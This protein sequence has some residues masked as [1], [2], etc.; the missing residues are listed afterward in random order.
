M[1]SWAPCCCKCGIEGDRSHLELAPWTISGDRGPYP[2]CRAYFCAACLEEQELRRRR[3]DALLDPDAG[4]PVNPPLLELC[5]LSTEAWVLRHAPPNRA[6]RA[7]LASEWPVPAGRGALDE[8]ARDWNA[9]ARDGEA[10]LRPEAL[11]DIWEGLPPDTYLALA[12]QRRTPH[13]SVWLLGPVQ[14]VEE[15]LDEDGGGRWEFA[16]PILRTTEL[17]GGASA[18]QQLSD[19][20]RNWYMKDMCGRAMR[21]L[22]RPVGAGTWTTAAECEAAIKDAVATWWRR[23]SWSQRSPTQEDIA[24]LVYLSPRMFKVYL[25]RFGLGGDAWQRLRRRPT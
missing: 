11:G 17:P 23:S 4:I 21:A 6:T 1:E 25:Q 19:E 18:L 15:S 3:L 5:Q 13:G 16:D 7:H 24:A 20:L 22:G 12:V 2:Y 14:P 8:W 9:R 10:K